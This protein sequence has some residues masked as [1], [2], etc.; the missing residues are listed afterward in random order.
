MK[1]LLVLVSLWKV[2]HSMEFETFGYCLKSK[3]N[4]GILKCVGQQAISTLQELDEASNLT[5][6]RGITMVKDLSV[7]PRILPNFIDH[8]PLDF[9]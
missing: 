3:P 7:M 5:I 4:L 1:F 6:G 9:R 8:D 2:T